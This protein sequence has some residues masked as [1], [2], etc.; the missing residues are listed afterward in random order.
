MESGVIFLMFTYFSVAG[1]GKLFFF[2]YLNA[3]ATLRNKNESKSNLAIK[4][5]S[6]VND[7]YKGHFPLVVLWPLR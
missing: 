5:I 1:S 7:R 4:F 6:I 2:L 3:K